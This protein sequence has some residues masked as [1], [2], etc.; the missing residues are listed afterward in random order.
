[1]KRPLAWTG[2]LFLPWLLVAGMVSEVRVGAQGG[3]GIGYGVRGEIESELLGASGQVV[4]NLVFPFELERKGDAWRVEVEFGRGH[5]MEVGSDG[6]DVYT[7][8]KDP[9]VSRV[10]PKSML[11]HGGTVSEG[12]YPLNATWYVTMPWFAFCTGPEMDRHGWTNLPAPWTDPR[13]DP[14]ASIFGLRV[15]RSE[16]S[17][18]LPERMTWT[19][20]PELRGRHDA[21]G[22]LQAGYRDRAQ[23]RSAEVYP[24]GFLAAEYRVTGWAK[25]GEHSIPSGFELRRYD[26]MMTNRVAVV[27]RCSVREVYE[28]GQAPCVPQITA[29]TA[30]TDYRLRDAGLGIDYVNYPIT[31]GCWIRERTPELERLLETKREMTRLNRKATLGFLGP[32]KAW[33]S[34]GLIVLVAGLPFFL[35]LKRQRKGQERR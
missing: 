13:T 2:T 16:A 19:V 24:D 34:M 30:V 20:L 22:W 1:M 11:V 25:I 7:V 5:V 9:S 23:V 32:Y 31:N 8:L 14:A 10:A 21:L 35:L 4:T 12:P 27:S 17:P 28:V 6:G 29:G 26:P 3:A 15:V 33:V 18:W